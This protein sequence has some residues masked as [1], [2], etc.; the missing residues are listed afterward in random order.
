MAPDSEAGHVFAAMAEK[1]D[2]EMAPKRR[3]TS[4]LNLLN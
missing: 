3:Y 1:L 2:V 4:K